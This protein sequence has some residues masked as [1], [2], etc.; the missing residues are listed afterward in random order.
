V[1]KVRA[2]LRRSPVIAVE[3]GFGGRGDALIAQPA[4]NRA[5]KVPPGPV[6]RSP[7]PI[8][9]RQLLFLAVVG[10]HVAMIALLA[11]IQGRA[12]QRATA[13][14]IEVRLLTDRPAT[15]LQAAPLPPV[16]LERVPTEIEV[17]DV[18]I[19]LPAPDAP[20]M[21]QKAVAQLPPAP[22]AAATGPET[23]PQ[24]DAAY[25]KNP[26]PAYPA[27]SRRQHQQGTVLL[28]VRV[29]EQGAALEVLVDHTSG[30]SALDDAAVK[31][32]KSWRFVPAQRGS[33][34]VEAWVLIPV[35]FALHH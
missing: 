16:N 15:P 28:K 27:G 34:P 14:A 30:W 7:V 31:A 20:I 13:P 24:F 1:L 18:N 26:A 4:R 23:P 22:A 33:A 5:A 19:T 2:E 21:V 29:S 10:L 3:T 17:P 9:P 11:S 6:R 25:L 8:Q 32:V 35:E 12:P